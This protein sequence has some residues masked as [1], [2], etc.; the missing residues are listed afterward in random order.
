M[1]LGNG[2]WKGKGKISFF[3]ENIYLTSFL[4]KLI[5]NITSREDHEYCSC[6]I[7]TGK[8]HSITIKCKKKVSSKCKKL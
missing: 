8:N 6:N 7:N 5:M 1:L 4:L 3:I 2:N